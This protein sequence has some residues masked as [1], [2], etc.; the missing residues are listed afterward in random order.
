[1]AQLCDSSTSPAAIEILMGPGDGQSIDAAPVE[2]G[3]LLCHDFLCA[4]EK[5]METNSYTYITSAHQEML[6]LTFRYQ[7]QNIERH[8]FDV[9]HV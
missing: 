8:I 3:K 9:S 4:I 1:M 2:S 5:S 6:I 7:C